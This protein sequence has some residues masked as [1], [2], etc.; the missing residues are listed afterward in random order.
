MPRKKPTAEID[1]IQDETILSDEQT[2]PGWGG[3]RPRKPTLRIPITDEGVIDMDRVRKNP[4]VLERARMALGMAPGESVPMP[5]VAKVPR[6][7]VPW[8]YDGVAWSLGQVFKLAK[9]PKIMT[10]EER[11]KFVAG[12]RYSDEFK[13]K[14]KEPTGVLIDRAVGNSKIAAWLMAHSELAVLTKMFAE[15]TVLMVQRAAVPIILARQSA[16]ATKNANGGFPPSENRPTPAEQN[17]NVQ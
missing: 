17:E 11:V 1:E 15:E 6:E 13:E 8:V 10:D 12:L 5:E 4:E 9:W 2:K 7:F 3:P 14:A 16:E